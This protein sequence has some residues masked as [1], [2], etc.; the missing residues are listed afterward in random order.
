MKRILSFLAVMALAIGLFG[1]ATTATTQS[2]QVAYVQACTAYESGFSAAL[3]LREQGKLNAEQISAITTLDSHISTICEG[4]LPTTTT[5]ATEQ[6]TAAVT[7][8]TATIAVQ[9]GAK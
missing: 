2:D 1:C 3:Q 9:Q 8:L 5:A 4:S 6:I 7:T